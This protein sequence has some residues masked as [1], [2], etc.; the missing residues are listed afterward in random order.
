MLVYA[1]DISQLQDNEFS[2]RRI[3]LANKSI[4][5]VASL[6]PRA[7]QVDSGIQVTLKRS[8]IPIKGYFRD[9]SRLRCSL[10][11]G[12]NKSRHKYGGFPYE[13]ITRR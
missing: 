12:K 9:I 3:I 7:N 10:C 5:E 11:L 6:L 4:Y 13:T 2:K 8:H 1:R